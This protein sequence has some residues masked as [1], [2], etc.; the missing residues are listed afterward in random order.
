MEFARAYRAA[1]NAKSEV[2]PIRFKIK[3]QIDA[4]RHARL[5]KH[6][7]V[8]KMA[9]LTRLHEQMREPGTRGPPRL[10]KMPR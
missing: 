5:K 6:M 7:F 10:G 8:Y 4:D 1:V 3:G 2:Q 9:D